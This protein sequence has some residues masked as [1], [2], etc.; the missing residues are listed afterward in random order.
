MIEAD[1]ETLLE[2]LSSDVIDGWYDL[3]KNY[4]LSE[5]FIDKNLSLEVFLS[6][7][8]E[9]KHW[10]DI[11][12]MM[13][14]FQTF[15]EPF[16]EKHKDLIFWPR[17]CQYQKLSEPFMEKHSSYLIWR[18]ISMCQTLSEKFILKHI[19]KFRPYLLLNYQT[20]SFKLIVKLLKTNSKLTISRC[21][22]DSDPSWKTN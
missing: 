14:K 13:S 19:D 20:L 8:G 7:G 2:I 16:M 12:F 22:L 1:D 21:F 15:S 3:A 17:I 6:N 9:D 4:K 5:E 11:W 18:T 10:F